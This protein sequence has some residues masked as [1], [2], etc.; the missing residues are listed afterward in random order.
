MNTYLTKKEHEAFRMKVRDFAE[1]EIRPIAV[2]LDK[3]AR[4]PTEIFGKLAEMGLMGAPWPE[5]YGGLGLDYLSFAIM[6][7]EL[8]RVDAGTGVGMA[9]HIL[10]QSPIFFYGTEE[11]KQKYLPQMTSGK[12]MGGFALTEQNSG[13]D[14]SKMETTAER[15]GDDYILN[16]TKIFITNAPYAEIY[17][18]VALTNPELGPRGAS[19]FIVEKGWEGF[20]IAEPY[21]KMGIRSSHTCELNFNNVRVPRANMLGREGEGFRVFM[22]ALD[23]GRIGIGAQSLGIAQGAYE[24]AVAYSR[25]R[26]Q[27]G[28]PIAFNQAISFKIADM[29]TKLRCARLLVYSAAMLRDSGQPYGMEASMAKMYASDIGNEVVT[30]AL[31]IHGGSG[32]MKGMLVERAYRDMKICTIYEGT[33]EIQRVVISS[34]IVGKP[35]K[36]KEAKKD[37]KKKAG[38][39]T[40]VRKQVIFS[41][42]TMKEKVESLVAALKSDGYDFTVE[43]DLNAPVQYSD[44]VL[45]VGKGIGEKSNLEKMEQLAYHL[46]AAIACSRPVAESLDYMPVNR[47]IGMSGQKFKNNLYFSVGVSGAGQHLKGIKQAST[48]VAINTNGSAAIFKNCDYGIVGDWAEILPIL[49]EVLDNGEPKKV[50]EQVK[51]IKRAVPKKLPPTYKIYLCNGCAYEYDQSIGDEEGD[52]MPGT[53]FDMLPHEW[54]CPEC[55]EEKT[56]FI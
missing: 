24:E 53:P 36:D 25:E 37:D 28:K 11:Q 42:G 18:V 12:K 55:G 21:D 32:Y 34:Y 39:T 52:I 19:A 33:N 46:G 29:A 49:I 56:E 9:V 44:R 47:Y 13:S 41:E 45:C 20:T 16:G 17:V 23:G 5:E 31:Q 15:D 50:A 51:K 22:S 30:D 54:S 2:L 7:E 48:I 40:G 38:G 27:F 14:A 43:Q 35:P 10:S 8:S 1:K 6:V 26:V 3:E 4:F